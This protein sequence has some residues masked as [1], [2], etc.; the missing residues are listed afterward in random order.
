MSRDAMAERGMSSICETMRAARW[1][2]RHDVRV[3]EV[4]VPEP[5]PDQALVAVE[6]CGIC[7]TDLEEYKEGP[8]SIPV[9]EPHPLTGRKAPVT[10]GHEI[11]GRV[12]EPAR[13]GS[14][15]PK[16]AR[17]SRT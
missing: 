12:V 1:H 16:G 11:V 8:V 14:G 10:L 17:V 9:G 15:P 6:W 7:G 13:D 5:Q 3:E 2:G 4:P